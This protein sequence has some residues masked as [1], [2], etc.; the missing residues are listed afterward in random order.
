[1]KKLISRLTFATVLMLGLFSPQIVKA[2]TIVNTAIENAT[3]STGIVNEIPDDNITIVESQAPGF[4]QIIKKRFIEGGV[5]F[6]ISVLLCLILGIATAI[7][8]IIYLSLSTVNT[9]ALLKQV[10][11]A[12][13]SGGVE[14]AK[15]VCR[16]TR[17]PVASIFYDGLSRADEGLEQ[18]EK[19]IIAG[20][21]V[22]MGLMEKGISWISLFIA[23]APMLGFLG[24]VLGMIGAFDSIADAGGIEPAMMAG[25][26]KMALITT[27]AGLIVAIFLQV[28]YNVIIAKIDN[29]VNAMENASNVFVKI[30]QQ[31]LA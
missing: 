3:S 4:T 8:R 27:V 21:S 17:G 25:D 10:E 2:D 29:L 1:M 26:I 19:A 15:E 18:V 20:G 16:N 24:T 31:K 14:A 9:T 6:M 30:V 23:L 13:S 11:D 22:Q 28:F 5:G 7:E 12:L